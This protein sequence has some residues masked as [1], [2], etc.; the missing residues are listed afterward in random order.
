[1]RHV[2]AMGGGGFLGST[3]ATQLDAFVLSLVERPEPRVCFVPTAGGDSEKEI[4][5][6]YEIFGRLRCEPS[7]LSLF[8]RDT[9][10]LAE[11]VA[12]QDV[13]YVAGGNTANLLA[14]WRLHGLDLVLSQRA[15]ERDLVVCGPSAGGLCWFECGVTDSFTPELGPLHDGLGW[16][17]GSF[18]PHYDEEPR[19]RP[20]YT[21]LVR[22]GGLP[23]GLAADGG[24]A[25]HFTDGV[26]QRIVAERPGA[27]VHAVTVRDG[28]VTEIPMGAAQL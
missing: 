12:D 3:L 23:P 8:L 5:H 18:C 17:A 24:A 4:A 11:A 19:R 15:E 26:L 28:E 22:T 14:V 1:M 20:V 25:A 10:P 6:F 9:T 2:V 16:L 7:H 21:E 13:I 27:T